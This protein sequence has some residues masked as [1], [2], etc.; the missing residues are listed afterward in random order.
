MIK[1]SLKY[2]KIRRK[3]YSR[4]KNQTYKNVYM[5]GFTENIFINLTNRLFSAIWY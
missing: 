3:R 5:P 1:Y 4:V 2:R